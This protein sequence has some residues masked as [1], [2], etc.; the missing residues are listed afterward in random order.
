ML[1]GKVRPHLGNNESRM[2]LCHAATRYSLVPHTCPAMAWF[3][4]ILFV[5]SST[6]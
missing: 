5:N 4:G 6:R 3:Q 1:W 2:R